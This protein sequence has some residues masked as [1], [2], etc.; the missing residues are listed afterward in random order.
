MHANAFWTFGRSFARNVIL[1][2][3]EP[4]SQ[5]GHGKKSPTNHN[6]SRQQKQL[7]PKQSVCVRVNLQ[8]HPHRLFDAGQKVS[9]SV[10]FGMKDDQDSQLSRVQLG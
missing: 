7:E 5:A 8:K 10:N 6:E 3:L 2:Y 4:A 1:R 9:T